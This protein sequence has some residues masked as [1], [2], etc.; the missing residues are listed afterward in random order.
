MARLLQ[1]LECPQYL[2]KGIFPMHPD[3]RCVGL[4]NPLDAT[5]HPRFSEDCTYREGVIS[6]REPKAGQGS[7]VY[8][9]L[10]KDVQVDRQLPAGTRVTVRMPTTKG[11]S[12]VIV[13]PREPRESEPGVAK[14]GSAF[15]A[16]KADAAKR[17]E[18]GDG[19]ATRG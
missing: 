18:A 4:L 6:E 17:S 16:V 2:R 13:S 9:G 11:R 19:G 15:A 1:Y 14:L 8:V 10:A 7:W 5:N 3:L 12:A